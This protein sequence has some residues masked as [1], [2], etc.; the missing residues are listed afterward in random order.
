M[1]ILSTFSKACIEA[2]GLPAEQMKTMRFEDYGSEAFYHELKDAEA[3]FISSRLPVDEAL[4]DQAKKLRLVQAMGVGYEMIDLDLTVQRGIYACNSRGCNSQAVA[5]HALG[6]ILA[7]LKHIPFY[8]QEVYKGHFYPAITYFTE[9]LH[10]L[11]SR[12]VGVIGFGNIAKALIR[13]LNAFGCE[14]CYTNRTR[15]SAEVEASF[16]VKYLPLPELVKTCNVISLHVPATKDTV[17]MISEEQIASMRPD[18]LLVNLGRGDLIDSEALAKALNEGRIFGA[19][20][21]T[22]APEPPSADHPLLNLSDA[23][24]KRFIITPHI[25]GATSESMANSLNGFFYNIEQI[26]NGRLP[27]YIVNGLD[28]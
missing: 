11:S 16:G 25:G 8:E 1:K 18:T 26:E 3:L 15:A 22:I 28:R 14:I 19:A 12:K 24:R 27:R 5:E 2:A 20:I 21:D 4:L 9:G 17:N 13:M 10:Q 6:L 23:G 7:G